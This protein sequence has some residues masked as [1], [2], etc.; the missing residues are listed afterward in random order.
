MGPPY[1][2]DEGAGID[3][4]AAAWREG[5]R[6]AFEDLVRLA[7]PRL[8]SYV[9]AFC[10]SAELV[11]EVLQRTF[12]S[13]FEGIASFAGRGAFLA[14]LQ[15]IARNHALMH[16]RERQRHAQL[17]GDL[18]GA[19]VAE[20]GLADLEEPAEAVARSRAL[21]A[22]LERLPA[23][24]RALVQRRHYEGRPLQQLARDYKEPAERLSVTLHRIRATLRRCMESR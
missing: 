21:A 19:A 13:C 20:E 23:R 11:D 17:R 12:I 24:A 9:A 16:W 6:D 15:A 4:L 2:V 8:R 5:D 18:A 7:R 10:D 1:A 22:C 14:W 3:R